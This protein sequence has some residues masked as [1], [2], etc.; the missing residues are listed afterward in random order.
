MTFSQLQAKYEQSRREVDS[1]R[2]ELDFA[3][4]QIAALKNKLF[5]SKS[6]RFDPNQMQLL[7]Q[8]LE[9]LEL[10]VKQA[11]AAETE[12]NKPKPAKRSAAPR[13]VIPDH[14]E[15]EEVV[16]DPPQD[17]LVCGEHGPKI[18]IGE[19]RTEEVDIIPPRFVK[20]VYIRGIFACKSCEDKPVCVPAPQRAAGKGWAGPGLLAWI[21]LSKYVD[22]LPLYRQEQIFRNRYHLHISRKTMCDWV[23]QVAFWLKPIYNHMHEDLLQVS[24]LHGDETPVKFIDPDR[25]GKARKGY[26]WVLTARGKDV[27]FRFETGRSARVLEKLLKNWRGTLHC[28]DYA[29]YD[30]FIKSRTE[31]IL[32][33]CWAHVRRKFFEAR[34][35][36]PRFVEMVLR[37]IGHLYA[38]DRHCREKSLS[39]KLR[40]VRRQ[41]DSRMVL[42]RLKRLLESKAAKALPSSGLGEA[43]RYALGNW[44]ELT[45]FIKDG[46]VELDNNYCEN[47]LR[48]TAV[49]KKNWLFIGHPAAGPASAIIYSVVESCKRH[50][51]EPFEYLRD[52]LDRLPKQT[53]QDIAAFTPSAWAAARKNQPNDLMLPGTL[54]QTAPDPFKEPN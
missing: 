19:E 32:A 29:A 41:S 36:S 33:R 37:H 28:D 49:G 46:N 53:N 39:P 14:L 54:S 34:E 51:V 26:L 50:G 16:L 9:E 27:V 6:E 21:V 8:G 30:A 31:I 1:L 35:E 11:E 52:V 13:R 22:H 3:R 10:K 40:L 2:Q 20:R 42:D 24:Y 48:S 4:R 7:L 5:G 38:V 17:Q 43:I 23:Q 45:R 18:R 12:R 44:K 15:V 25:K 47:T